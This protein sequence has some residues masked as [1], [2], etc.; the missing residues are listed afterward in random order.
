MKFNKKTV[1]NNFWQNCRTKKDIF[2]TLD[3]LLEYDKTLSYLNRKRFTRIFEYEKLFE[4]Y[5]DTLAYNYEG[6][7]YE[8]FIN[9]L[10]SRNINY[11]ARLIIKRFCLDQ[12]RYHKALKQLHPHI[13]SF[14]YENKK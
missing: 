6:S 1:V 8:S 14:I 2:E 10:L 12:E 11:C 13:W 3:L 5:N 4:R 7:C 9:R